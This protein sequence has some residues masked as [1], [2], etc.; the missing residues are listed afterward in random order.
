MTIGEDRPDPSDFP[1]KMPAHQCWRNGG[2]ECRACELEEQ[3]AEARLAAAPDAYG[4]GVAGA[5]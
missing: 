2:V 4:V 1:R 5:T 3:E